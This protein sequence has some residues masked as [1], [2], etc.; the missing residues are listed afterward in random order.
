MTLHK[1][2][3]DPVTPY[4]QDATSLLNNW[5]LGSSVEAKLW[6]RACVVLSFI[7]FLT[8]VGL[9]LQSKR[10]PTVYV[11]EVNEHGS[12]KLVGK[13]TKL[14]YHPKLETI[15]YFLSLFIN[16]I[17]SIPTDSIVLKENI[18]NAY[19]FV[20]SKGKSILNNYTKEYDPFAKIKQI[21]AV[22]VTI[23]S[24]IKRSEST[25]QVTWVEERFENGNQVTSERYSGLFNVVIKKPKT[26]KILKVN[27]LGI[28]IDFFNF[29]KEIK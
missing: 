21:I 11:V 28:W 9:I 18:L 3:S 27:P 1:P 22:S 25:Y 2:K 23:S 26:E 5:L 14:I 16:N 8:I 29:S 10:Y 4:N 13:A 24:V 19:Q 15:K 7:L 20:T 17:R 12:V 6:R